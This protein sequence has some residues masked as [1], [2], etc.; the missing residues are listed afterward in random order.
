M[1]GLGMKSEGGR[2]SEKL[3]QAIQGYYYIYPI[4]MISS[5]LKLTVGGR[6]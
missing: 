1:C 3:G 2:M 4:F 5:A 6:V